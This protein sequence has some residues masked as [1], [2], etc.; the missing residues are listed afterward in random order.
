MGHIKMI[1]INLLI[2][3]F[4]FVTSVLF[5]ATCVVS[6]APVK[7]DNEALSSDLPVKVGT[8][9]KDCQECPE[10][11]P[12]PAVGRS[13]DDPGPP[14]YA[15]RFEL[16]WRQYI[17]AIRAGACPLATFWG[18]DRRP[19]PLER[20]KEIE[21][22]HPLV[23]IS[24][25]TIQCYLDWINK[26]TGKRYRI[27]SGAEWEHLARGG[28]RTAYPWGDTLRMNDAIL[29]NL[30]D[31][32]AL[33]AKYG[34]ITSQYDP[35]DGNKYGRTYPVG[36]LKPNPWGLYDVIGNASEVT[37]E[38]MEPLPLC[39]R[40]NDLRICSAI[41]VRGY[42]GFFISFSGPH[43]PF[44]EPGVNLLQK[45]ERGPRYSQGASGYRFVRN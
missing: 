30:F 39:V 37:T 10:I 32:A 42:D 31:K 44:P 7:S 21:D 2:R 17:A 11:V 36:S 4:L 34:V 13:V 43:A 28:T 41:A 40:N 25:D 22:N 6:A 9:T 15:M 16:T 12:I 19:W 23:G 29:P 1:S 5:V 24:Y 38:I 18:R 27:P 45:K 33:T 35:R 14:F 8:V 26:K 3:K 20:Y